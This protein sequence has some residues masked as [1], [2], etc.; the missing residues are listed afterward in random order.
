MQPSILLYFTE[1]SPAWRS[2]WKRRDM[3]LIPNY[4]SEG[5]EES[6][7][8]LRGSLG[9]APVFWIPDGTACYSAFENPLDLLNQ[10]SGI[11]Q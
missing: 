7:L 8:L 2:G 3:I 9:A 10:A 11:V 6:R 4:G 1:A 5:N